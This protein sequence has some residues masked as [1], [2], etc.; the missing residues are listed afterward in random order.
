MTRRNVATDLAA[1]CGIGARGR[2]HRPVV[3]YSDGH[4][5]VPGGRSQ[6]GGQVTEHRMAV[7]TFNSVAALAT[8]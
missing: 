1:C 3:H 7:V 2:G 8:K 6:V 5:R 4:A